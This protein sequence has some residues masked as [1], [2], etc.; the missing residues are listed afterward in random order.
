M[1]TPVATSAPAASAPSAAPASSSPSPSASATKSAPP[2]PSASSSAPATG[3]QEARTNA[4]ADGLNAS[5][6]SAAEAAKEAARKLKL[7]INGR[8]MELEE[9]E[10]IRRAQ[11]ASAADEKFR[12]A[13]E[14]RKQAEQFFQTLLSDPKSVLLH[15][16]LRDKINFRQLAEEFLGSELKRE[17]MS[18]EERELQEL[19]EWRKQQQEQA[20]NAKREQMTKAQREEMTRLQQQAAKKYDQEITDILSVS[21]LPKNP[22]TV[23][24]VAELLHGALS[25][26]YELDVQTAVDMVRESYM[27]DVQALVGGLDGEALVRVLG[28]EITKKLRK[29]DLARLKAQLAQ[30]Q[31][32]DVAQQQL[33]D[34]PPRQQR[35]PQDKH[36]RPDEWRERIMRK[37]GL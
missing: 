12:E 14:M 33:G 35:E 34:A 10:V 6:Q 16:E 7:K 22:Y 17:L 25:K 29:H 37:A 13:A 21:Q 24:R 15:P 19:R 20:E 5:N 23:K 1:S 4:A 32:A 18:P 26:G 30:P 36:L 3:T 9:P 31:V 8:E 2:T 11:L 27:S 28:D